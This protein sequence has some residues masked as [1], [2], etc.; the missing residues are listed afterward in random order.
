[1][2]GVGAR[3]NDLRKPPAMTLK[4]AAVVATFA[5]SITMLVATTEV[6]AETGTIQYGTRDRFRSTR[7]EPS[8]RCR[9]MSPWSMSW[10]MRSVIWSLSVNLARSM[11]CFWML[12]QPSFPSVIPLPQY[13]QVMTISPNLGE[14]GAP[15]L[16]HFIEVAPMGAI[17]GAL[18]VVCA[19]GWPA[20]A[21][22]LTLAPHFMQYTA[23]SGSW[24]PHL[25]QYTIA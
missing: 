16:G 25:G 14:M 21:A 4:S 20:V 11:V 23:S 19:C 17:T 12:D 7:V 18:G 24:V 8:C 9:C 10:R 5:A 3:G 6:L 15:Q 1:N 13:S 22:G 2:L